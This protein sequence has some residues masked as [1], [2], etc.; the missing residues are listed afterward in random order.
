[1]PEWIFR[2]HFRSGSE[3]RVALIITGLKLP[4]EYSDMYK[5]TESEKDLARLNHVG[6]QRAFAIHHT[7]AI[8]THNNKAVEE[9]FEPNEN[10][11]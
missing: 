1:M 3:K 9:A 7:K 6:F 8:H 10:I 2:A 4:S 11:N 5:E